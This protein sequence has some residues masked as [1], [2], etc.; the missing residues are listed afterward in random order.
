[1]LCSNQLSYVG[2]VREYGKN[3]CIHF[4][5]PERAEESVHVTLT[6]AKWEHKNANAH[7]LI[8]KH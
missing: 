1:M 6:T 3:V 5:I 7:I 8:L 4:R 2:E